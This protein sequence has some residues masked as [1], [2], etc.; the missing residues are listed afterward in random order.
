MAAVNATTNVVRIVSWAV[1]SAAAGWLMTD[2]AIAL[3]LAIA[4]GLKIAYDVSLFVAFR[5][6]RPPEE[7]GAAPA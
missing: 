1:G 4:A 2:V 6:T 7:G 5:R 3:P